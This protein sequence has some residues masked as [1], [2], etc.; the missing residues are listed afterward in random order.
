MATHAR[1]DPTG[2]TVSSVAVRPRRPVYTTTGRLLVRLSLPWALV[3]LF[4]LDEVLEWV[5]VPPGTRPFGVRLVILVAALT[6]VAVVVLSP[7]LLRFRGFDWLFVRPQPLAVVD[8]NVLHLRLPRIGEIALPWEHVGSMAIRGRWNA[9]SELRSPAGDVLATVPDEL[10][11]PRVYWRT[12]FTLAESVVQTRPDRYAL[13]PGFGVGR[14]S[15]FDLRER[16]GDGIDGA[17]WQRSRNR[18]VAALIAG[19]LLLGA[20]ST[21]LIVLF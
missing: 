17:A 13:T 5:G 6:P 9:T 18:F 21:I 15:S 20:I 19:L 1:E 10:V 12:A 2:V 14:P 7:V 4:G 3:A 8:R 11:H 16:V